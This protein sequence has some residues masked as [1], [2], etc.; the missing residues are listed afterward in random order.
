MNSTKS[1]VRSAKYK[2]ASFLALLIFILISGCSLKQ[3][4][5]YTDKVVSVLVTEIPF[6][7]TESKIWDSAPL[8][9]IQLLPQNIVAPTLQSTT[10]PNIRIRS[11]HNQNWIAFLLEWDDFTKDTIIDV[12]NFTDQ[13]AIQFPLDAKSPPS[14]TMG[15]KEGRVQI[16]HWKA[17]WQDD[18]EKG[19]RDVIMLHPHY[20]VDLYYFYEKPYYGEGEFAREM[21]VQSF[22]SP[23]ALNYLP[24][25]YSQNPITMLDRTEPVEEAMAEGYGTFTS[26]PVQNSRGWGRWK[27]NK[28]RVIISRPLLTNDPNDAKLVDKTVMAFAVWNGSDNNVGC[29]KNYAQWTELII[30]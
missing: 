13:C 1:E 5:D 25:A 30:K 7:N 19:Y 21:G 12:D 6:R 29:R 26:Q 4:I 23:E 18:I 24:G 17:I 2:G 20:W 10:V 16:I 8:S 11:L 3:K 27:D 28:W 15:H 14:F 22:K 9:Q